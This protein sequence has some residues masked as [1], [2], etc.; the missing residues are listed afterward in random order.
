MVVFDETEKF[1]SRYIWLFIIGL[2]VLIILYYYF[3]IL[4]LETRECSYMDELYSTING[5]IRSI[6]SA[7]PECGYT[8]KD[9]YIKSAYNCC[10][11]G[12]YKNDF[13]STCNLKSIL[14]QGVRGLDFEI[15]NIDD[16]PVVATSTN[17]EY[18]VKETYNSVKF[19]DVMNVI[20]NYAF[21]G[22][23]APNPEDPII[24]HLRI[25][26]SNQ[27]MYTKFASILKSY[28]TYLLGKEYSY[29][30]RNT[31]LGDA[32]LLDL[33]GKII[34][35]VDRS[36]TAFMEN[37]AFYEYVNMTSNSI[38]MRA[39][40]YYDI[41][42]A[43]DLQELQ[44]YNKKNM[45]IALPDK[46]SNPPNPSG[47]VVKEAGCQLIAMR[48]QYVDEYL[49]ENAL[50]FDRNGYAFVLKPERLRYV[51]ETIP[52]PTA[53]KEELSYATREFSTNY[54]SF[55]I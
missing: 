32:K 35:I 43:P 15:Y 20:V 23:T 25:K 36:N 6:S 51:P 21:S 34:I 22:S 27:D 4:N 3:F 49:L 1:V 37:E 41:K 55:N 52:E 19:A 50:F 30:N 24:F 33:K 14:R 5:N 53:Q 8:F 13:V 44:V 2:I 40:R 48:Y 9:Y 28:E 38:F 29:E 39:L 31:N 26:S 18:F 7:D 11:G 54:Y 46:G 16:E 12:S 47:M 42:Y 10:S 17:D 45:T